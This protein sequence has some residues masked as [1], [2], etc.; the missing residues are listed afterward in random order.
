MMG[1]FLYSIFKDILSRVFC[2]GYSITSLR[3]TDY[4]SFNFYT[5]FIS[6]EELFFYINN[7]EKYPFT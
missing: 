2:S 1:I 4:S 5:D 7:V 3:I 6:L